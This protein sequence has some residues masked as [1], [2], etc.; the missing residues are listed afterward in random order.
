[1]I[2]VNSPVSDVL[3]VGD[4]ALYR[5]ALTSALLSNGMSCIRTAWDLS[6]LMDALEGPAPQV[7]LLD[8]VV[9]R[10]ETYLRAIGHLSPGVPVIAVATP[11]DDPDLIF[12]CAKAGVAAYHLRIESLADLL[13]LIHV[14]AQGGTRCPPH[15]AATLLR[16]IPAVAD[17]RRSATRDSGLTTREIQVL[18]MLELGRSNQQIALELS[19]A[20]HTVK[21]HVH[22]LLTKL[23]VNTRA[24]A[25]AA[26]HRPRTYDEDDR[27]SSSRSSQSWLR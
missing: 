23:G 2:S 17:P 19:I 18:H 1:M 27:R 24:E 20:V 14:A 16:R 9:G 11:D 13:G 3:V 15:I 5:E 6:S 10:A 8:T 25:A 12:A 26:F 22:N 21:N 4:C 7:I